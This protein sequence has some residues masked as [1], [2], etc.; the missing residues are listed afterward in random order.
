MKCVLLPALLVS[1]CVSAAA[2][3]EKLTEHTVRLKEG[4][5]AATADLSEFQWL[6]GEWKGP[7]LGAECH[8]TWSAPAGGCMV[9]TFRMVEDDELRFSEFFYLIQTEQGTVLRVKHFNPDFT[10]WEEKDKSVDFPLVKVEGK[11][12]WFQG[13]TYATQADGSMKVFVAMKRKDGSYN[14][15]QFHFRRVTP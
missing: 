13:L 7:G 3:D 12:A 4:T 11:T 8:E 9:G 15:G 2:A 1:C 10:G 6:R 14:E 5:A